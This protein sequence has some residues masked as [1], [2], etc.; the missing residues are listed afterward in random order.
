METHHTAYGIQVNRTRYDRGH[1]IGGMAKSVQEVL[2]DNVRNL[3]IDRY[4]DEGENLNRLAREAKI[5]PGT[6][7]RIKAK[8]TATRISTLQKI[9]TRYNLQPWHL[10]LPA[11]D[12]GDPPVSFLTKSE[13]DSLKKVKERA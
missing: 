1:T 5:G 4:G 10:L 8:V 7:S 2:W 3:M 6:A 12:P 9:A 13:A 11:L